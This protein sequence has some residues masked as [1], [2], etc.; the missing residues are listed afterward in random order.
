MIEDAVAHAGYGDV[1]VALDDTQTS[2]LPPLWQAR[3]V[4]V[5]AAVN[6]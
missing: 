1:L 2:Y 3:G 6:R 4:V 5:I